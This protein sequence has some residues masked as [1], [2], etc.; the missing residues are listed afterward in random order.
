M[1]KPKRGR[2]EGR[3]NYQPGERYMD[4]SDKGTNR[5]GGGSVGGLST[6][7]LLA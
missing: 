2:L 1:E 7:A 4:D 6:L 3:A 5:S